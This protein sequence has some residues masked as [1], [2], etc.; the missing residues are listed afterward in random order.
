MLVPSCEMV[1]CRELWNGATVGA[2]DSD[3]DDGAAGEGGDYQNQDCR[4]E[5]PNTKCAEI[6]N[7]PKTLKHPSAGIFQDACANRYEVGNAGDED[8]DDAT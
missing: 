1:E 3:N 2:D 7:A 4:K 6:G 8:G 5:Q